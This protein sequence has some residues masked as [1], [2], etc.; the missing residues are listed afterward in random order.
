MKNIIFACLSIILANCSINKD[1]SN[2][3]DKTKLGNILSNHEMLIVN[4]MKNFYSIKDASG[5]RSLPK[6]MPFSAMSEMDSSNMELLPYYDFDEKA[7]YNDPSPESILNNLS[8]SKDMFFS[9]K[10]EGKLMYSMLLKKVG[11]NWR[12]QRLREDWERIIGW[13][14]ERLSTADSKEYIIFR[15]CGLEYVIYYKGGKPV[16]CRITGEEI[17]GEKLCETL[18]EMINIGMK[19]KKFL[20]EQR[21]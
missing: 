6:D 4:N 12:L 5:S 7:F 14:P 9:I 8:K 11:E 1:N 18:V 16:F 10:K 3:I 17:S 15:P 2:S 19:N 21:Q 13:L 20:E